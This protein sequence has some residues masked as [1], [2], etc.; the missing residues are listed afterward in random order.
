MSPFVQAASNT[1]A[2]FLPLFRSFRSVNMASCTSQ[3]QCRKICTT[4]LLEY[5]IVSD[6][7]ACSHWFVFRA[8]FRYTV[9]FTASRLS[10]TG[11]GADMLASRFLSCFSLAHELRERLR[12]RCQVKKASA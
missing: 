12:F 9:G 2:Q 5:S 1:R 3:V 6:A 7:S 8:K 11:S 4:E 10:E